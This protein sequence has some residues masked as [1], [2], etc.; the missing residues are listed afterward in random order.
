MMLL[1]FRLQNHKSFREEAELSLVRSGLKTAR[2]LDGRWRDYTHNVVALYGA[3]ASG[4]SS[5]LE[6]F[7]FMI[8]MIRNSA[9]VWRS[10]PALPYKP[11]ALDGHSRD[12]PSQYSIDFVMDEVRFEYG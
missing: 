2:P 5:V 10:R 11:F 7:E 12:E 9:T 6:A 3:N 8:S 1:R 4:K